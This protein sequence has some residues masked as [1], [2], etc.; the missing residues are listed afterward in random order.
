MCDAEDAVQ[1][2]LVL[3]YYMTWRV[4]AR[5][6]GWGIGI[7]PSTGSL[8]FPL[9]AVLVSTVYHDRATCSR[10]TLFFPTNGG[11]VLV[12]NAPDLKLGDYEYSCAHAAI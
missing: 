12:G 4:K 3:F 5:F 6:G 7:S 9:G 10:T 11:V 2:Y 8:L 1:A